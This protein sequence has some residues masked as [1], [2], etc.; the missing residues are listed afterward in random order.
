MSIL[1][2]VS[3]LVDYK[4]KKIPTIFVLLIFIW[5]L[6]FSNAEAY[7]KIAG[8]LITAVPL[9]GLSIITGE[10]KGGD[11][12]FLVACSAALGMNVFIKTLVVAIIWAVIWGILKKKK[13]VPLAFVFMEGYFIF[14]LYEEMFL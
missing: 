13:S 4:Y 2:I 5:S 1:M 7:E 10:I 14:L 12:K 8:F 3:G 9:L 6:F 11:Y